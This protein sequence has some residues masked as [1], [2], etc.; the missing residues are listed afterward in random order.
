[1]F[2]VKNYSIAKVVQVYSGSRYS[3]QFCK[4]YINKNVMALLNSVL[5]LIAA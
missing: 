4:F 5:Q 2:G 3:R 1:M